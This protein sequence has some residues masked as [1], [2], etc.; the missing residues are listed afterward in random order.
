MNPLL[1]E[2]LDSGFHIMQ[3]LRYGETDE[4]HVAVLLEAMR[5]PRDGYVID[6]GC[7]IGTVS[8]IMGKLRPDL[9]FLLV[10]NDREQLNKCPSGSRFVQLLS[11]Y[12]QMDVHDASVDAVMFNNSICHSRSW[13][14][15]MREAARV[16]KPGGVLF[17]NDFSRRTGDNQLYWDTLRATAFPVEEIREWARIAG[18]ERAEVTV[19]IGTSS[20]YR[21]LF[22]RDLPLET[23]DAIYE[24]LVPMT[25]RFVRSERVQVRRAPL[26]WFGGNKDALAMY[27]LMRELAHT[28]DDIVD[29]SPAVTEERV[30]RAFQIALVY[31][32]ANPFYRV[33]ADAVAP[34]WLT[35]IS[36]YA[37]ANKFERDKDEHGVELAHMLRYAAGHITAYA[38][39]VCI[40]AERAQLMLPD[41]WKTI[42]AERYEDYKT[43]VLSHA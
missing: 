7:G 12:S 23:Y 8:L 24:Q 22:A 41:M 21:A 30:N 32:P 42:V 36:A 26:E 13:L 33:I 35:T 37:V 9:Q 10:N 2:V 34:M 6:A 28:W 5:P 39:Q 4:Q 25:F 15:P 17:I 14:P 38:I 31:L 43:E 3:P 29:K 27:E 1:K 18:F 20:K 19:R 11:D 16:L 40:G